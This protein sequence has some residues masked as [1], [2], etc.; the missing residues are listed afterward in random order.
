M[1]EFWNERTHLARKNHKCDL[2]GEEIN[3]GTR[4]IYSSG[5]SDGEF[6]SLHHHSECRQVINEYWSETREEEYCEDDIFYWWRDY[7][8]AICKHRYTEECNSDCAFF[9]EHLPYECDDCT[10]DHKCIG[11]ETCD[12]MNRGCWCTK[13]ERMDIDEKI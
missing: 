3:A 12:I 2:C 10:R 9:G 11:G 6:Y 7:K 5:K 4:Y 1:L 8:C 13:F